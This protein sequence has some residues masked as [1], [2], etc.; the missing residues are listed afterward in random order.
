MRTVHRSSDNFSNRL[1]IDLLL[2]M[3][4]VFKKYQSSIPK[5]PNSDRAVGIFLVSDYA[6]INPLY[7]RVWKLTAGKRQLS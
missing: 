5:A 3:Q 2:I 1:R 6:P 4:F 7:F